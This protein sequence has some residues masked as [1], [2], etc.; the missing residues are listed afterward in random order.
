MDKNIIKKIILENQ[1]RIPGLQVID[2][3]YSFEPGT[4]YIIT[5]QRRV[6]KTYLMYQVIQRLISEGNAIQQMLYINFEDER[7]LEMKAS[8]L[9]LV[10]ESYLELFEVKPLLFFDE[11]QNID[12]WQKFARRL[13]DND[14]SVFI[15]GSNAQMLSHEI[16][17]TLGGRFLVKE[18]ETL[19]FSEYLLFNGITLDDN[20]EFSSQRFEIQRQFEAWFYFGGFPETIKFLDKK[21]YLSNLFQKV[22]LGDII[23]RYQIRNPY[24]VKL[25]IKKIAESTMDEVSFN[26]MRHIIS[27][28]GVKIGT[29]TVIDYIRYLHEAYLIG[30]INN[31][32]AKITERESKKKYYF[33]DTGIV[34]LFLPEP[35]AFLLET[36][37]YNRLSALFPGNVYYIRN[38]YV[39][40]FY[41]PGE[42][43]V[44]A[45][46]KFTDFSTRTR[47]IVGLSKAVE[48]HPV[49]KLWIITWSDE[50][51]IKTNDSEIQVIPV[52]KWLLNREFQKT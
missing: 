21:E 36:V 16:A 48:K 45:C 38:S 24:A 6:G 14:Y 25:L 18:V 31:V 33:R 30:S 39:V 19:S 5:G 42:V 20:M 10:M 15:T 41:I 27:S 8:D 40:D 43:L 23:G 52:W 44:Q 32:N 3:N 17:S 34:S 47:E 49:K 4:N 35:E 26:R 11:I 37:V 1:E 2:R 50:E 22:F 29:S 13:A 7:L 12:G 46:Y 28:T 51:L 9:D